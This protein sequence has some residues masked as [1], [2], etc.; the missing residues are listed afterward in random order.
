L[1]RKTSYRKTIEGVE[2]QKELGLRFEISGLL[3]YIIIGKRQWILR[4][5]ELRYRGIGA[6][7]GSLLGILI[8]IIASGMEME[9]DQPE[10][11]ETL[12]KSLNM[13]D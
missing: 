11:G 1:L 10:A 12:R 9:G 5:S 3:T 6:R 13:D 4:V 7:S 8:V 2:V